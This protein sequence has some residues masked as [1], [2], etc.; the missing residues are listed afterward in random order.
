MKKTMRAAQLMLVLMGG[1]FTATQAQDQIITTKGKIIHGNVKKI[2]NDEVVYRKWFHKYTIAADKVLYVVNADG[3]K[4]QVNDITMAKNYKKYNAPVVTSGAFQPHTIERIGNSWRVDTNRIVSTGK[5]NGILAQS[6]NPQVQLNLKAAKAI[7]TIG[8]ISKISSY[9]STIGGAWAS[10]NTF[11]TVADQMKNGPVSFKSYMNAGLSF[12]GTISL[13]I[14][15]AILNHIQKKKYDKALMSY[16][17]SVSAE[18]A[19]MK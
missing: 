16:S 12:L 3:K 9:P 18:P 13:P 10:F 7:R 14:T 11:K 1:I 4:T 15:N 8:I 5:L 2:R 19:A 17:A 6:P